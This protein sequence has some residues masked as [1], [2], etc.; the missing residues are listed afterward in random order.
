MKRKPAVL[1]REREKMKR[2]RQMKKAARRADA[3]ERRA[4]GPTGS[5]DEDP[6]IA[7]I[8]LGPQPPLE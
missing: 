3:A 1:K 2:E 8:R 6:D 4:A 7:G 5:G